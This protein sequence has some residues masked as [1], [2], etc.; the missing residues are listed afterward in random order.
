MKTHSRCRKCGARHKLARHPIAYFIQPR[1]HNCGARDWRKD[2]YR[3]AVELPQMRAKVGRY[4]PCHCGG[5]ERGFTYPHRPGS[6]LCNYQ[7]NGEPKTLEQFAEEAKR[8]EQERF[9]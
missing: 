5:H 9:G 2:Q 1:C 6:F 3:H 4:R 7:A 8:F